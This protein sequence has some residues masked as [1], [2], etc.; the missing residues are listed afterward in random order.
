MLALKVPATKYRKRNRDRLVQL[1]ELKD[2][3][4]FR[5]KI[6][7]A[8]IQYWPSFLLRLRFFDDI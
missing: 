1:Q 6:Y 8:Y 5:S 3:V 4:E 2:D 7:M